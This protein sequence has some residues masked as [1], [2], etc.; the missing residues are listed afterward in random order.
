MARA[1]ARSGNACDPNLR[2]CQRRPV[3]ALHAAGN[4]PDPSPDRQVKAA[5]IKPPFLSAAKRLETLGFDPREYFL[6]P[7]VGWDGWE[8]CLPV[9]ADWLGA[10]VPTKIQEHTTGCSEDHILRAMLAMD[11]N[12]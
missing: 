6:S 9:D 3:A 12:G 8:K 10:A 1:V 7:K 11:I 4:M 5:A 2:T